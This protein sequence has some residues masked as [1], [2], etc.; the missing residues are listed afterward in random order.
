MRYVIFRPSYIIGKGD[1]LTQALAE[2]I[3]KGE[4]IPVIGNGRYRM[5]PIFVKDVA[6]IYS[7]C[8]KLN[9]FDNQTFDLVGSKKVAYIDY[10]KLLGRF[11]LREP[12]VE[13]VP[14]PEAVKRKA[15]FGLNEDEI[16]VLM[17]DESGDSGRLEREFDFELTPLERAVEKIVAESY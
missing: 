16:D 12:A 4:A 7:M 8:M 3:R 1:E 2:K 13:Y 14:K 9:D 6:E 11:L 5:Q 17:C 15:E 10:I